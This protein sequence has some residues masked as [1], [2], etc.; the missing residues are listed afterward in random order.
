[1]KLK[2]ETYIS[3]ILTEGT[4]KDVIIEDVSIQHKRIED[5]IQIT[6]EMYYIVNEQKI[7]LET[8]SLSFHGM[9]SNPNSTNVTATFKFNDSERI[10]GLIEYVTSKGKFPTKHTMINWGFP[11]Y[12]DVLNYLTGGS[13]ENP[14]LQPVNEFA[15][16]W[17]I[18]NIT[19]KGEII[20]KQFTF[21]D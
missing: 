18:N 6:F 2:S 16:Q 9:N 13:F 19:M 10:H 14:E 20:N 11:S 21:V 12:E 8:N 1:M 3:P 15:K 7:V 17:I 4:F 5:Y